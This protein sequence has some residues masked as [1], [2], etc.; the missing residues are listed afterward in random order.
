MAEWTY[1]GSVIRSHDD[2]HPDC[3]AFVYILEFENDLFYIGK[4]NVRTKAKLPPLKG[5]ARVRRVEK[6]MKFLNYT[7]SSKSIDGHV[8]VKKEILYQCSSVKTATYI[9][10]ALLFEHD[11]IFS[12]KFLNENILGTFY[13]KD[14]QGILY[15]N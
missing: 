13:S 14:I 5:K 10:A 2:L 6:P 4:K 8:L 9:E 15:D 3:W 1:K 12:D 7:G 11:A